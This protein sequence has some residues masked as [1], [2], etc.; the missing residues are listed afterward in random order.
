MVEYYRKRSL[1]KD[2]SVSRMFIYKGT[3]DLMQS[4]GDSGAYLRTTMGALALFGAPPEKYWDYFEANLN[5]E[6]PA[7][8][9][10]YAQ[11]FQAISYFRLDS[12][13]GT[14]PSAKEAAASLGTIK[15]TLAQGLPAMFGFTVYESI[16]QAKGGKIPFP[17]PEE[18]VLGGHAV[19]CV[20]Y[21]DGLQID[22][23]KGA[24]IIRNSWGE[25]WGDKGYGYLSYDYLLRGLA[26]DWWALVKAEWLD[27]ESFGI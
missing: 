3:R 1:A 24:F 6:P 19:L 27:T 8:C 2:E 16:R 21:N 15:Q 25:N 10:S 13:A 18:S 22:S 5:A 26:Q 20:G 9:F 17:K 14:K 12:P 7:F 11:N 23:G 4:S